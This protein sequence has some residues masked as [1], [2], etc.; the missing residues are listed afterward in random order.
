MRGRG[1]PRRMQVEAE[2]ETRIGEAD[3]RPIGAISR[4]P[5]EMRGRGEAEANARTRRGLGRAKAIQRTAETRRRR[6]RGEQEARIGRG[7]GVTETNVGKF[8]A[9]GGEGM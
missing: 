1:E 4:P 8:E 5:R 3:A 9:L 7:P 2:F 6:G